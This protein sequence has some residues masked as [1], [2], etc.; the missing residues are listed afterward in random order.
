MKK[1]PSFK[2][3]GFPFA[4][5][6]PSCWESLRK[7]GSEKVV[8]A[9]GRV[10]TYSGSYKKHYGT[11]PGKVLNS[12]MVKKAWKLAVDKAGLKGL[13]MKDLRHTWK[14][15]AQRSKMD[16]TRG[17][18]S[19]VTRPVEQWKISISTCPTKRYSALWM[20]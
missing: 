11:Y 6:S 19:A 17:T 14:T 4:K 10:F 18:P 1:G 20:P 3:K 13:Q 7:Q 15:N 16:P 2:I 8:C 12:S 9:I 5:K